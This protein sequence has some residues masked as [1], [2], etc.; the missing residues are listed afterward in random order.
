MGHDGG[1]EKTSTEDTP[2]GSF[3]KAARN[4]LGVELITVIVF[5]IHKRE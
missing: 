2:Q 3:Q 4:A 1:L 5:I